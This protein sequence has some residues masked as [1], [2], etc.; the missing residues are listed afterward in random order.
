LV[1]L[2]QHLSPADPNE[3]PPAP[4]EWWISQ[5]CEAFT[6]PPVVGGAVDQP[7]GLTKRILALRSY[8][9][10]HDLVTGKIPI[11]P[12]K[13]PQEVSALVGQVMERRAELEEAEETQRLADE[14]AAKHIEATL[15]VAS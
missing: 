6:I 3:I 9:V 4:D 15:A 2:D 5:V 14:E 8:K 7:I 10:A 1:A 12:D 13:I 11:A